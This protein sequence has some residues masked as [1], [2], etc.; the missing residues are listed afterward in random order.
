MASDKSEKRRI[1]WQKTRNLTIVVLIIWFIFA[2]VLP[3]FAKDLNAFTFL[4]FKLGYY[5]VVQGSLI[6]FVLLII[7]QNLRQDAIDDEFGSGE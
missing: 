2:F 5:F 7:V 3:W 1:H 4:G 6:V